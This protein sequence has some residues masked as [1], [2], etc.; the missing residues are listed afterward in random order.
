MCAVGRGE[1]LSS[2]AYTRAIPSASRL[3]AARLRSIS[4][5]SRRR[6][7]GVIAAAAAASSISATGP[8][9][10]RGTANAYVAIYGFE[11]GFHPGGAFSG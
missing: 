8:G 7:P 10:P 5:R 9:C 3:A 6:K 4:P 2:A 1:P 11:P